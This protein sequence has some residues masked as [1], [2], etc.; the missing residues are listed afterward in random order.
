[1]TSERGGKSIQ[2]FC[3]YKRPLETKCFLR[4]SRFLKDYAISN[5]QLNRKQLKIMY[6]TFYRWKITHT[7]DKHRWMLYGRFLATLYGLL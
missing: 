2:T 1:M 4:I 5:I 6:N 7:Q 3:L